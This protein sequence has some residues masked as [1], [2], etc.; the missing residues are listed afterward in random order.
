M[1]KRL[2]L[3]LVPFDPVHDVGI[4][5]VGDH[6]KKRGHRV[7]LLPPDLPR[8]EV[9]KRA[10]AAEYDYILISRT[11]GY[12]VA[13][14]LGRLVGQMEAAALRQRPKL[15]LGGKAVTPPLAAALGVDAGFY[16][17][18]SLEEIIGHLEGKAWNELPGAVKRRKRDVTAPYT[19]AYKHPEIGRLLDEIAQEAIDWAA[20]KTTPGIERAE[21]RRAM[22]QNP[23]DEDRCL[24]E[25][26]A[27]CDESI[28]HHYRHEAAVGP[29]R[30][31]NPEEAAVLKSLHAA[32]PRQ[33]IQHSAKQ[34]LVIIFVG[35]GCPIMDA[36]HVKVAD[37]WGVDGVM[38]VCP[39]WQARVEGL[40]RGLVAQEEDGTV[41]TPANVDLI[42]KHLNPELYFQLRM[43][44]GLNTPEMAV[45]GVHY[46]IDFGK[47]TP[48]YGS[49][50]GGTDPARLVADSVFAMKTLTAAGIPFDLPGNDELSGPPAHKAFA[51][52]L[53]AAAVGLKLGARPILK[54]LL[55]FSPYNMLHGQMDDNYVDFNYGK[56]KAL[57]AV[58]DAP[59]WCGEPVGFNT[60][61][62][63][64]SASTTITALHAVLAAAVGADI[65]TFAST[66]ESYSRGPIVVS[67][68][69]D[70]FNSLRLAFR[71]FG[72]A[73]IKPTGEA[74]RHRD[75]TLA[76]IQ[77]VLKEVVARGSFV[78]AIYAGVYGEES[79][80]A[81][82]GRGGR[83]TVRVKTL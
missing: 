49:L 13:E 50:H 6:L 23:S 54:P 48:V 56:I 2:N 36:A 39:S 72:Q 47:I 61:E 59:I 76:G 22:L 67:S 15:V 31:M 41:V 68:R 80:G 35:S 74:E 37:S 10:Q 12:G 81:K 28:V 78:E 18:A 14:I 66:D 73:T 8:E 46:G 64:R 53:T 69:I 30:L 1:A 38:L 60:H 11:M 9:I 62:D 45:L 51:G 79:E 82:P 65:L 29:T 21:I 7:R 57:Q 4:R 44:R 24:T 71:F 32:P 70:T 40:M 19:Y 83:D 27:L 20:D 25:Y 26:L 63:D 58:L 43:H 16:P 17:T 75:E 42:K 3:L 34:P 55:C 77:R 33:P 52:M 5:L